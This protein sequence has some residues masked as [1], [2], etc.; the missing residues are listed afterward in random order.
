MNLQK[1]SYSEYLKN[2]NDILYSLSFNKYDSDLDVSMGELKYYYN[3]FSENDEEVDEVPKKI[4][5]SYIFYL[6]NK[7]NSEDFHYEADAISGDLECV[8]FSLLEY[9][10]TGFPK[11]ENIVILDESIF[12]LEILDV[13]KKIKMI[14]KFLDMAYKELKKIGVKYL[15]FMTRGL[16]LDLDYEHRKIL[17]NLLLSNKFIPITGV[18]KDDFVFVKTFRNF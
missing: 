16:I 17:F 8:A 14:I 12:N 10:F 5:C 18:S 13:Y 11:N 3:Y 1:I 2:K 4:I 6:F 7:Y 15:A 9:F